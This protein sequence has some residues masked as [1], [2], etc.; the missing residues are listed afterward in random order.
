[1]RKGHLWKRIHIK[2]RTTLYIPQ[3]TQDGPDVPKLIPE[4]ATMVK[5]TSGARWYRIDDDWT[6]K[7]EAA[8]NTTSTGSTNLKKS[9]SYK[10]EVQEVDEEDPQQAK[11][12]RAIIP[13]GMRQSTSST[14]Q[15]HPTSRSG[16]SPDSTPQNS[17]KQDGRQHLRQ[18]ITSIRPTSTRQRRTLPSNTD[19]TNQNTQ[20]T[21]A[22]KLRQNNHKQTPDRTMAGT[23]HS[24]STQPIR[25]TCGWQHQLLPQMEQRPQ[26]TTL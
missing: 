5:P 16:G 15:H 12:A 24:V 21:T 9:T 7:R 19:G 26:I 20:S 10:D 3:Q 4:R 23:T 17:S 25:D 14:Q 22:T 1:M 2:P 6:T 8:L 11:P 18:A 13:H